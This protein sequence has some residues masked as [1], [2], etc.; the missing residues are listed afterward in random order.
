[1]SNQYKKGSELSAW[2]LNPG[3][4][5]CVDTSKPSK[6]K[7]KKKILRAERKRLDKRVREAYNDDCKEG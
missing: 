5:H 3:C 4:R 1:M 6:R 7:L 2:D